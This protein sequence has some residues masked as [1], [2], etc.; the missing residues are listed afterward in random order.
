MSPPPTTFPVFVAV[1]MVRGLTGV[2]PLPRREMGGHCGE[3]RK[4]CGRETPLNPSASL[5]SKGEDGSLLR[6]ATCGVRGGVLSAKVVDLFLRLGEPAAV[7][8]LLLI[9]FPST[10]RGDGLA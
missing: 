5:P 8:T 4:A 1:D 3:T 2:E 7:S 9:P 6:S 10:R